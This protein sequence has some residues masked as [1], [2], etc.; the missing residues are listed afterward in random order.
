M[1]PTASCIDATS[2]TAPRLLLIGKLDDHL[3]RYL[4]GGMSVRCLLATSCF[5][6]SGSSQG[7]SSSSGHAYGRSVAHPSSVGSAAGVN[8]TASSLASSGSDV[9]DTRERAR[10]Q[11]TAIGGYIDKVAT[12][13]KLTPHFR[14]EL[15]AFGDVSTLWLSCLSFIFQADCF[16]TSMSCPLSTGGQLSGTWRRSA[17]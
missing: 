8:L 1:R 9:G 7:N 14:R 17:G 10:L 11:R 12:S 3:S 15:H 2:I 13:F 6:M 5:I 4:K 16:R